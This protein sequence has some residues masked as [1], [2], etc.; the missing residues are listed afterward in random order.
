MANAARALA[1]GCAAISVDS[2]A[3][4]RAGLAITPAKQHK[5]Q[6][7]SNLRGEAMIDSVW[8]GNLGNAQQLTLNTCS[9]SRTPIFPRNFQSCRLISTIFMDS[10]YSIRF[11]ACLMV[12]W[13]DSR[14]RGMSRWSASGERHFSSVF[15]DEPN[16]SSIGSCRSSAW[17]HAAGMP[18]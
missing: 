5:M 16:P 2:I 17:S 12:E 3:V 4:A 11:C 1:S 6:R 7:A 15:C 8:R 9:P 13:S 18:S 10:A 14:P